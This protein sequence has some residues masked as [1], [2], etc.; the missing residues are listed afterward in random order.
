MSLGRKTTH[1]VSL[2]THLTSMGIFL[3]PMAW[4]KLI[5]KS[6]RQNSPMLLLTFLLSFFSFGSHSFIIIVT[7]LLL[8]ASSSVLQQRNCHFEH[9]FLSLAD[10]SIHTSK[11]SQIPPCILF[12]KHLMGTYLVPSDPSPAPEVGH[13][14]L[15][16]TLDPPTSHSL[17]TYL[18]TNTWIDLLTK[19]PGYHSHP[20]FTLTCCTLTQTFIKGSKNMSSKKQKE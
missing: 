5:Q 9:L 19:P 11:P 15:I 16:L 2:H 14:H 13:F 10:N 6:G 7:E 4:G 8:V 17:P 20:T 12:S 18:Q 1:L 3:S